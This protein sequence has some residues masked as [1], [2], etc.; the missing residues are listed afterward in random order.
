MGGLLRLVRAAGAAL[1]RL[2]GA[3]AF[4]P[5]GLVL[6]ATLEV[7]PQAGRPWGVA[8]LDR[9]GRYGVTV[10]WSR[11]AG[12]PSPLPDA[13]G[14]AL[15]VI[16]GAGSGR[17]FDLLLTSSGT[18]RVTRHLPV[19][20]TDAVGGAYSTLTSYRFPD[21][22]RVIAAIPA[23]DGGHGRGL[24]VSLP[25]LARAL[26]ERPPAVFRLCAAAPHEPWRPFGLLTVTGA[27]PAGT[28][29][30]TATGAS[31][32][33]TGPVEGSRGTG[34]GPL[35]FDPYGACLPDLAPGPRLRRWREAAYAGSRRARGAA[36]PPGA[37]RRGGSD[38]HVEA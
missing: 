32:A 11:A 17:P 5:A 33:G 26:A 1:A 20:R 14:L 27:S 31:P 18:G 3:R 36:A 28:G 38:G 34:T 10:R 29:P 13:L 19:L 30:L 15:R 22:D 16:D 6:E 4:H 9:A 2:R 24:P 7:L 12:L 25:D 37:G 35:A 8:F 23:G 21:R